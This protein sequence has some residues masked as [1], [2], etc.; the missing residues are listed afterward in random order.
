[1]LKIC[2][3]K[4]QRVFS[5]EEVAVGVGCGGGRGEWAWSVSPWL[6]SPPL[7]P[8]CAASLS[9]PHLGLSQRQPDTQGGRRGTGEDRWPHPRRWLGMNLHRMAWGGMAGIGTLA[10][11]RTSCPSLRQRLLPPRW[12]RAESRATARFSAWPQ[13]QRPLHTLTWAICRN[14]VE[15][16]PPLI[17]RI[18]HFPLP[19]PSHHNLLHPS[20]PSCPFPLFNVTLSRQAGPLSLLSFP[21]S[22]AAVSFPSACPSTQGS[23]DLS[24]TRPHWVPLLRGS[25]GLSVT[26]EALPALTSDPPLQGACDLAS[27]DSFRVQ[28]TL[29][30]FLASL[31]VLCWVPLLGTRLGMSSIKIAGTCECYFTWPRKKKKIGE[32]HLLQIWRYDSVKLFEMGSLSWIIHVG[33]KGDQTLVSLLLS[34]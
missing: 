21:V 16:C 25:S 33:P 31:P 29:N 3:R 9:L 7:L 13:R 5:W 27:P 12:P 28:N 1:M 11:W 26:G 17:F 19:H 24:N 4:L 18:A 34:H 6:P 30:L 23:E 22:Q 8:W 32:R 20:F 2:R 15:R 14:Q 10:C